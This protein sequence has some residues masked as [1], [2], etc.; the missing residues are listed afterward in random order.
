MAEKKSGLGKVL[1]IGAAAAVAGG[2]ISYLKRVEIKR[3]TEEIM[4]KVKPT[5]EE[6]IY[7]ADLDDDG[8]PDIILA[9]TTGD[10][11]IDTVLMDTTGDGKMDSAAVDMDGDGVPDVMVSGISLEPAEGTAGAEDFADTAEE[12]K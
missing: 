6:G 3:I 1:L 12:E 9:D 11:Q 7:T 2:V 10:G 4:A 8:E 5:D